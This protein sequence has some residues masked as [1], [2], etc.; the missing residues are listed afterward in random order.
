MA[1]LPPFFFIGHLYGFHFLYWYGG[2]TRVYPEQHQ[3]I[4]H[5]HANYRVADWADRLA[6]NHLIGPHKQASYQA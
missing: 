3:A 5:T 2:Y 4:A 6:S 1:G